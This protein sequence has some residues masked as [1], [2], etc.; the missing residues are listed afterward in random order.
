MPTFS[1]ILTQSLNREH[2][3]KGFCNRCKKYATIVSRPQ[4]RSIPSVLVL[5]TDLEN[6][7]DKRDLWATPGWLPTE[8]A[9]IYHGQ[10]VTCFQGENLRSLRRDRLHSEPIIYDLV[11]FVA[12]IDSGERQKPHLVSLVNGKSISF[13]V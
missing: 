5:N 9:L 7:A 12:D 3:R 11:G 13:V 2:E 4:I 1:D 8:I 10:N 6:N